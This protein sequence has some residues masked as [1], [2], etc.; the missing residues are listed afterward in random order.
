MTTRHKRM[1]TVDVTFELAHLNVKASRDRIAR[2]ADALWDRPQSTAGKH[3][4]FTAEQ[5][6][7]LAI[8]FNLIDN[9][10]TLQE[11]AQAM[12][13]PSPIAEKILANAEMLVQRIRRLEA[14]VEDIE[15][16]SA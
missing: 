4:H 3:R 7:Q 8:A 9:G 14:P 2:L 10:L 6:D 13:D 5:V 16:L 1:T 11:I 12:E 15:A